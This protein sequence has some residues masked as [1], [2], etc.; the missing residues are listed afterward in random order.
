MFDTFRNAETS[1][2]HEGERRLQQL[3]GAADRLA[4]IGPN[5]LRA[6]LTE[7]HRAFYPLLPFVA[8]GAVGRSGDAWATLRAG[9]PGFLHS[10][11]PLALVIDA[12]RD[13][14]D[15]AEA[16]MEDGDRIGLLGIDRMT[17]RRNR[18]NGEVRRADERSFA[19][20]VGQ[21]FGNCP[22]YIHG[23]AYTF[24]RDLARLPALPATVLDRLDARACRIIAKAV[25]FYV[26]S[27]VDA[28]QGGRQVDVSH[29]GGPAG[30]VRMDDDGV[31]TVPDYAG[32]LFFN[33]LGNLIVNPRA[34]VTFVDD[35]TG[36]MLQ[37][38]GDTEVS[39]TPP[40]LPGF[41]DAER[42]WRFRPRRIV[43]RPDALPL[44]WAPSEGE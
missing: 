26:A 23:R 40:D 11:D 36:D 14:A 6:Y 38:T 7:Q 16:G 39:L 15:P 20:K 21:S 3:A 5:V 25:S 35:E 37:M 28:D 43:L 41:E 31:L 24:A 27:Y 30:F 34:G 1:C 32:N 4:A 44:R 17:R 22:R 9:H 18:L 8:I 19:V 2:W 13:A 10:P 42:S 29:R 33:T 12:P